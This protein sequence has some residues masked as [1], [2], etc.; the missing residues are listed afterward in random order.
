MSGPVLRR[1]VDA[2]DEAIA[3]CIGA[4]FPDNPK[5]RIDVLRWQYRDNPFGPAPTWV[6]E[7]EGRI[8]AHYT[9]YPVPYRIDGRVARAG[10]A[11]DAAA[12]GRLP[13]WPSWS[14]SPAGWKT[15]MRTSPSTWPKTS[16]G[17]SRWRQP[18]T[19]SCS[20]PLSRPFPA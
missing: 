7:D 9:A 12:T 2:D 1:A 10:F 6:W 18:A 4:A 5:S 16:T 11:V 8:V 14:Q 19:T 17:I 20:K 3:A 15:L 13:I